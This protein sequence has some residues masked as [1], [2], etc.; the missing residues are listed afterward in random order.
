MKKA[1]LV[2]F[3]VFLS[4]PLMLSLTIRSAKA[5]PACNNGYACFWTSWYGCNY[6]NLKDYTWWRAYVQVRT[7][8]DAR[9]PVQIEYGHG[10]TETVYRVNA[11]DVRR[12]TWG[13]TSYYQ[14]GLAGIQ[15]YGA[16][17]WI[18]PTFYPTWLGNDNKD[19]YAAVQF[20]RG[21]NKYFSTCGGLAPI[22]G[23]IKYIK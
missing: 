4:T 20:D 22:E 15:T 16:K 11:W 2:L 12:D 23:F 19:R 5:Y 6:P 8:D 1:I 10:N 7:S 18:S 21:G 14:G 3:F 17:S 13:M 9:R